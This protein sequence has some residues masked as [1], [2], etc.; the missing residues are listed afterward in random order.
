MNGLC[1]SSSGGVILPSRL[2][3]TGERPN[4]GA[5]ARKWPAA[6][7]AIYTQGWA[8]VW[9]ESVLVIVKTVGA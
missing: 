8:L 5:K 7:L 9:L 3:A 4:S 2:S 1:S 6:V